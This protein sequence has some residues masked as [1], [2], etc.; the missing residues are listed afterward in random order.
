[1]ILTINDDC[2]IMTLVS[3]EAIISDIIAPE[4]TDCCITLEL[5]TNCCEPTSS[6]IIP[7]LYNFSYAVTACA[8]NT[9]LDPDGID[10][11]INITGID[12]E[13][14]SLFTYPSTNSVGV[15]T[16]DDPSDLSFVYSFN[17]LPPSGDIEFEIGITTCEDLTYIITF[18][19]NALAGCGGLVFGALVPTFPD[20]PTGASITGANTMELTPEIFGFTGSTFPDGLYYVGLTQNTTTENISESDTLFV[21]CETT[22]RVIDVLAND[23]CSEIYLLLEALKYSFNCDTITYEQQCDLWF[24]IAKELGYFID[25]P[26]SEPITSCGTCNK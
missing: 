24:V 2:T 3:E 25:T 7:S 4:T 6:I 20:F 16:E 13:C 8:T 15:T 23:L 22:C 14:V 21:D 26:C 19:I 10:L 1:M 18:T 9:A 12:P 17:Q 11:T 5:G